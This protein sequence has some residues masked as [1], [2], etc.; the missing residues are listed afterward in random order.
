LTD[1]TITIPTSSLPRSDISLG[2]WTDLASP[3]R[4]RLARQRNASVI[5]GEVT[6]IETANQQLIVNADGKIRVRI[7][8]D[9]LVLAMGATHSHLGHEEFARFP[10]GLKGL[11]DAEA[12]TADSILKA[13]ESA[14]LE[15][16]RVRKRALSTFVMVGAGPTGVEMASAIGDV[17]KAS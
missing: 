8:Y 16:G 1:P 17:K 4:D 10:L 3:I 2:F 14:E 11:A 12:H 5:L 7:A 13:F 15:E 9:Y 6:G